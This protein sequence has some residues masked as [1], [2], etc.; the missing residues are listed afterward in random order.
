[1]LIEGHTS[2]DE[3]VVVRVSLSDRDYERACDAHKQAREVVVAGVLS[4]GDRIDDIFDYVLFNVTDNRMRFDPRS[5]QIVTFQQ[6]PLP[7][8]ELA[9]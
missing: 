6:S 2:E 5:K 1:M 3:K 4:T 9:S 7:R 8:Q